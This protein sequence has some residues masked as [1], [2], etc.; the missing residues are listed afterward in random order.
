MRLPAFWLRD[1]TPARLLSPLEALF[2]AVVRR[3]R[4]AYLAGRRP[5]DRLPVPVVVVGNIFLGGTGKTPLVALLARRL[6][7]SEHRPGIVTR[8]HGGRVSGPLDVHPDTTPALAGDEAVLLARRTGVPVV[9]DRLRSRGA[10]TLLE[11]HGCDVVVADDGLQHYA[12]GRDREVVVLDARRGLGNGRCLPAGPLRE[13]PERLDSV[14]LVLANGGEHPL[15]A[16]HFTLEPEAL[17]PVGQRSGE[18]PPPGSAVHAVAG[19]G[20]PE[21][22]F[23]ALARQGFRV[24]PHAFADHHRFRAADLQFGDRQPVVMTEKDAVKCTALDDGRLWYQGVEARLSP[25]GEEAL[26]RL[27]AGLWN[28]CGE[29]A[30]S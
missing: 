24:T 2:R 17:R 25:R 20:H 10:R 12:L 3:R 15:A 22:F 30:G 26:Q 9:A 21:R 8:G 14:D 23:D 4:A 28:N 13:P 18:P 27:L 1:G 5:V 7:Q 19:I 6:R 11:H 29:E 16:G